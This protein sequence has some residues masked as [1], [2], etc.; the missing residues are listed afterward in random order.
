MEGGLLRDYFDHK[1]TTQQHFKYLRRPEIYT[2][3][4]LQYEVNICPEEEPLPLEY[5]PR[6]ANVSGGCE[7][8][9]LLSGDR[10]MDPV[11]GKAENRKIGKYL[12]ETNGVKNYLVPGGDPAYDCFYDKMISDNPDGN[13]AYGDYRLRADTDSRKHPLSTRMLTKMRNQLDRL[14]AKYSSPDDR[15]GIDW[16]AKETAQYLVELL[17]EHR[18]DLQ[19]ELDEQLAENPDGVVWEH[20]PKAHWVI[21]PK[22]NCSIPQPERL[23]FDDFA[24]G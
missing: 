12:S 13:T 11:Y 21:F 10:L 8:V 4:E 23:Y 2:Y 16:T 15:T 20:A 19:Q 14:I 17:T 6:C 24:N 22:Q 9:L 7:P 18:A 3:G 1:I 5:D